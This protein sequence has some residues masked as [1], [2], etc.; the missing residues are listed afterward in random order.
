MEGDGR[1]ALAEFEDFHTQL[2]SVE[3][4]AFGGSIIFTT[5]DWIFYIF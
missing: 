5:Q 2:Q 1:C 4:F 3:N